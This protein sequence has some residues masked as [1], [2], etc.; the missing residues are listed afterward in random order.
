MPN[1]QSPVL[2]PGILAALAKAKTIGRKPPGPGE[3]ILGDRLGGLGPLT[4][5][6]AEMATEGAFSEEPGPLDV[7]AAMPIGLGKM[8]Q[9][10]TKGPADRM[11]EQSSSRVLRA[12][13]EFGW[14]GGG[15]NLSRPE[16]DMASRL[17]GGKIGAIEETVGSP[18]VARIA[19]GQTFSG[20]KPGLELGKSGIPRHEIRLA[21]EEL[22]RISQAL[23]DE[24][25]IPAHESVDLFRGGPIR[26]PDYFLN[27]TSVDRETAERFIPHDRFDPVA[28]EVPR[29]SI[30]ALPGI[31]ARGD[32]VTLSE[33]LV[34]AADLKRSRISSV[35]PGVE[36]GGA[37]WL[38][39]AGVGG[40]QKFEIPSRL[41]R[42]AA[43]ARALHPPQP[44]TLIDKRDELLDQAIRF[45]TGQ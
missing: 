33:M 35:D 2:N 26:L 29:K 21:Q 17:G 45:W 27:P 34:P 39:G 15:M 24:M 3:R 44:K 32:D 5:R 8:M 43:K 19:S 9:V 6:M 10:L 38:K 25:G 12:I 20:G 28:Y 7:M 13:K 30:R 11:L 42:E 16:L 40:G 4:D 1:E 22:Y 37:S 18:G 31:L 14:M 41:R 23:L 36:T